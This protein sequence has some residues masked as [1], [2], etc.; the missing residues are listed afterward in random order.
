MFITNNHA[1]FHLW[2]K[3]NLLNYQ[4]VSKYNVH[5]SHIIESDDEDITRHLEKEAG[6]AILTNIFGEKSSDSDSEDDI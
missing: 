3:E 6:N 2:W 4:K 5:S 1:S